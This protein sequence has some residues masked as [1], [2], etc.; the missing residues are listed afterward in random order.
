MS[1]GFD[2][3]DTAPKGPTTNDLRE[4]ERQKELAKKNKVDKT[5]KVLDAIKLLDEI[6]GEEINPSELQDIILQ[7]KLDFAHKKL[8]FR[9]YCDK[10][11]IPYNESSS[12]I[13]QKKSSN[14]SVSLQDML[15]GDAKTQLN[16]NIYA[17]E[18]EKT[19]RI[20]QKKAGDARNRHYFPTD[21]QEQKEMILG[22]KA[23]NLYLEPMVNDRFTGD[24]SDMFDHFVEQAGKDNKDW[25]ENPYF[26]REIKYEIMKDGT[27]VSK[28]EFDNNSILGSSIINRIR[29]VIFISDNLPFMRKA[30]INENKTRFMMIGDNKSN[31][32]TFVKRKKPQK[33]CDM[34]AKIRQVS[35]ELN[36][37]DEYDDTL[38]HIHG[39]PVRR[40]PDS[41]THL[42]NIKEEWDAIPE[43]FRL[44]MMNKDDPEDHTKYIQAK[45]D[46]WKVI[47]KDEHFI[48]NELQ[49]LRP[50]IEDPNDPD[51]DPNDLGVKFQDSV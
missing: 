1:F 8:A 34:K 36:D 15:E 27:T 37:P 12:P 43:A 3:F 30:W 9:K 50:K 46:Y 51:Y 20:F 41:L 48:Q 28:Y 47:R 17:D 5:Q 22:A 35:T 4:E 10:N 42:N 49:K 24:W 40:P 38:S 45:T 11:A 33:V 23:W 21:E 18:L 31:V 29:D 6:T 7:D 26:I 2:E 39:D 16:A 25:T 19:A 14:E 44:S 32:K 13:G